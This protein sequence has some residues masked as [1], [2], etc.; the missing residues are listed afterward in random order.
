MEYVGWQG[1][2]RPGPDSPMTPV[3]GTVQVQVN[4]W[5]A[6]ALSA[7]IN[8]A[9]ISGLAGDKRH[10]PDSL[11]RP[12]QFVMTLFCQGNKPWKKGRGVPKAGQYYHEHVV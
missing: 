6:E 9:V 11:R 3:G 2:H 7:E 1:T 4:I 12:T 5:T 10:C 8:K